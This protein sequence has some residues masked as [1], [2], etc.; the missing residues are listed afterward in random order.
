[1]RFFFFK[2]NFTAIATFLTSF[3]SLCAVPCIYIACGD[4]A[5]GGGGGGT[6]LK[7]VM[8]TTREKK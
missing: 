7:L 6:N 1:M 2:Y 4:R 3:G 8:R 5:A